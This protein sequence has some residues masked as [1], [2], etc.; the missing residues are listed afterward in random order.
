MSYIGFYINLDRNT[1]RKEEIEAQLAQ[2]RLEHIYQR[3][4][5]TEGN[6]L[7]LPSSGLKAGEIGCFISHHLL[8]KANLEQNEHLHVI[9]DDILFSR[10][11]ENTIQSIITSKT[12]DN[13][14]IIF[15]D[16]AIPPNN[17]YY[18]LYKGLYEQSITRDSSGIIQNIKFRLVNLQ[19]KVFA[20]TASYVINN[21]SIKKIHQIY[22]RESKNGPRMPVDL[23]IRERAHQGVLRVGCIFP[24]VTSIRL[25]HV[26]DTTVRD[27][28][29]AIPRLAAEIARHSFFVDCDWTLCRD[30]IKRFLSLPEDDHR[31]VLADILGFSLSD[32]FRSF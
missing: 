13:Y 11:T 29:D 25:E 8:I 4:R 30:Y 22:D 20:S 12:F 1:G 2:H 5:A 24:F 21:K 32:K 10:Y 7:N 27:R 15:T 9:E 18:K 14:D 26:I 6:A 17:L 19:D 23:L 28:Y 16:I 31:Q 3:F